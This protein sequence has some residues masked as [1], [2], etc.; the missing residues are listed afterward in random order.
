MTTVIFIAFFIFVAYR[1]HKS[2]HP[3]HSFK[4]FLEIG[5]QDQNVLVKI[6]E[7]PHNH[8]FYEFKAL[9]FFKTLSVSGLLRPTLY[10]V[11]NDL[12]VVHQTTNM[13]YRLDVRHSVDIYQAWRIRQILAHPYYVLLWAKP[14]MADFSLV[15]LTG[16]NWRHFRGKTSNSLS[17]PI[18]QLSRYSRRPM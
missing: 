13:S 16:T 11:W 5:N 15:K 8:T 12:E 17:Y 4:I 1:S 9:N 6:L 2:R 14:Q 3:I 7:L 18:I 10:F